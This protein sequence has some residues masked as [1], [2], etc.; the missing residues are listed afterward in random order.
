[1]QNKTKKI[2]YWLIGAIVL[3][4]IPTTSLADPTCEVIIKNPGIPKV[5]DFIFQE[6]Q[7]GL[8]EINIIDYK[9]ATFNMPGFLPGDTSPIT[10]TVTQINANLE[11]YVVIQAK[12]IQNSDTVCE[13]PGTE[14][15]QCSIVSVD[16]GPPF[17]VLFSIISPIVGLD[18]ITVKEAVNADVD[19]PSFSIGTTQEILVEAQ[20][21]DDF[22]DFSIL[23]EAIDLDGNASTCEYNQQAQQDTQAPQITLTSIDHG[24]PI[25]MEITAQDQASGI[26]VIN[27][28]EAINADVQIPL[29]TAGTTGQVLIM[30][31]QINENLQFAVE[32][33]VADQNGNKNNYRYETSNNKTRP[34]IDIVGM[35]SQYFFSDAWINR[36]FTNGID[37]FGNNINNLSDFQSEYFSTTAGQE[38]LDTCYST[39][40]HSYFSILTP[41][42]TEAT[43]SWEIV[44]QMKPATDLVLKLNGCVLKTGADD[45]WSDGY[46]TGFYTLPWAPT[47]PKFVSGA[48]PRLTVHALPGDM[49]K[50]GFPYNGFILDTRKHS[51]LQVTP[52]DDSLI[53]IQSLVGESIFIVLPTEGGINSSGQTMHSLSQGDRIRVTISIPGNTTPDVRLG[54][55]GV[56]LQ[57]IGIKGTEYSTVN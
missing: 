16:P 14:P 53:T 52:L 18:S 1:M 44:L 39:Q 5:I 26:Q 23:L 22:D 11:F 12:D 31:Y 7:I 15:P 38:T 46:Q 42:W 4:G 24:P 49:A 45:V 21:I 13:Y 25:Q 40:G 30:A 2:I 41:T 20:I 6:S 9:N 19:I 32:I 35:D 57:Y 55:S 54:S 10:V 50:E 51:G 8:K 47:Q 17:T 3:M 34:E 37:I 28:I 29:F 43:Y 56:A 33:E 27:I 36:I 48:N